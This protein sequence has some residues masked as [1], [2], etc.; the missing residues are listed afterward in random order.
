MAMAE[1]LRWGILGTGNIAGQFAAGMKS[2]RRGRVVAVGSRTR[3]AASAFASR[4]DFSAAYGTYDALLADRSVE[5]VYLSLPNSMHREWTIKS[6]CAGK[7]VLC[8][9]PFSVTA[10]QAEEM[11][12]V[13]KRNGLVLVEA[14][15]YRS[16]PQTDAVLNTIRSGAIGEVKIIKTSFCYRTTRVNEN[17]R[18]R[19]ELAGGAMMDIGCYCLDFS[20]MIAGQEPDRIM[21]AGKLHPSGVD[22]TAAGTLHF[23]NGIVA[24][25][26]CGMTVQADN[27]ASICGTEGYIDI[28][29][30]WKPQ[31]RATYTIAHSTP[32]RQDARPGT[33]PTRPPRQDFTVEA[34]AEL[35]A[36]EADDFAAT[37]RDG[38]APR[39]SRADTLG[40]M[41]ALDE[42]RRQIGLLY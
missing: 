33:L 14:F 2:S 23:P 38:A 18:F 34:D 35:Y 9:K 24:G 15:M 1:P 13:A 37:V 11:F 31:R 42:I 10:A 3:E 32:P 30:P 26:V 19:P 36:L 29:W 27:T 39:L 12:D 6:L 40:N 28:P 21:A 5:A 22:E 8:E 25:F 16:H 4:F 20:R 17:I 41:R 7:H